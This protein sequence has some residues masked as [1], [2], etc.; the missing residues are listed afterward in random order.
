MKK[1][2]KQ[3]QIQATV[4]LRTPSKALCKKASTK[5]KKIV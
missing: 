1:K 4:K 2:K 3:S 5:I